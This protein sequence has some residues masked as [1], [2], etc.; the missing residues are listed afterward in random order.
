MDVFYGTSV[1]E[2][3]TKGKIKFYWYIIKW[4]CKMFPNQEKCRAESLK[5]LQSEIKTISNMK[6]L[7]FLL[8]TE[9]WFLWFFRVELRKD[10][11]RY[12]INNMG[13]LT[14]S[15]AQKVHMKKWTAL[16][17]FTEHG[18]ENMRNQVRA[19]LLASGM[20]GGQRSSLVSSKSQDTVSRVKIQHLHLAWWYF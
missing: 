20:H 18:T 6:L 10:V 16:C 3:H 17:N 1:S 4:N 5:F 15:R 2:G 7:L 11:K 19:D 12:F 8:L 14:L 9:V 13:C